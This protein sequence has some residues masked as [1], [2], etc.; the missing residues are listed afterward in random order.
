MTP[1]KHMIDI[2]HREHGQG[3]NEWASLDGDAAPQQGS[4]SG[5]MKQRTNHHFHIGEDAS[6]NNPGDNL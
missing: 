1:G 4:M 3:A 5:L 6:E 2:D